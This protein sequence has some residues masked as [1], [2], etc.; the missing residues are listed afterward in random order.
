[1]RK[2]KMGMVGGGSDAFIGAVHRAGA[3]MDGQVEF[4]SGA[5]SLTG[6][7]RCLGA[8]SLSDAG[9]K[10]LGRDARA[11][12]ALPER[13][14]WISLAWDAEHLLPVRAPSPLQ[15][16][17]GAQPMVLDCSSLGL[18][19]SSRKR[20]S[21]CHLPVTSTL[22]S[23]SRAY[24]PK[25]DSGDTQSRASTSRAVSRAISGAAPSAEW[26]TNQK[27]AAGSKAT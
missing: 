24:G 19:A 26:R 23:G 14:A 4:V 27:A 1:M 22:W 5:L 12:V 20:A 8:R 25:G 2:L 13:R 3:L 6:R 16:K 9:N 11:G 15:H 18:F 21:S 17:R 10:A 7:S